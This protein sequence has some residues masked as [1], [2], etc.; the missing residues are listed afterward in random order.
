MNPSVHIGEF[1]RQTGTCSIY[2]RRVVTPA[3]GRR[4]VSGM[5]T[6]GST[7]RKGVVGC[8]SPVGGPLKFWEKPYRMMD[9]L[10][11]R[12][13][14]ETDVDPGKNPVPVVIR[15]LILSFTLR[16]IPGPT[17]LR[18]RVRLGRDVFVRPPPLCHSVSRYTGTCTW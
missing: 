12:S 3:R 16:R 10:P 5:D 6:T 17:V 14:K 11:T 8:R 13:K 2:T 18:L 1:P 7:V 15:D 4:L 9:L